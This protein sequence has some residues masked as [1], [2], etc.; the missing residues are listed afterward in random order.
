[1]PPVPAPRRRALW[2][3]AADL[4]VLVLRNQAGPA[5]STG[6]PRSTTPTGWRCGPAPASDSGARSTT[7]PHPRVVAFARQTRAASACCSATACSITTWTASTTRSARACGSSRSGRAGAKGSVQLIEIPT[8]DEIHDN[9]VAIW[10]PRRRPTPAQQLQRA[11]TACTGSPTS[12]I[13][14]RWRAAW[15]PASAAVA[16][17]A[18]APEG[19]AQVH[20]RVPGRA[21]AR[22]PVW[23]DGACCVGLAREL[24]TLSA[25]QLFPMASRAIGALS[26][27]LSS[28]GRIPSKCAR[29]LS[30]A[31]R[32]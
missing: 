22:S 18:A 2:H 27:T 5:A 31:G 8:D 25:H 29:S 28:T 11:T 24:W 20:G 1:M 10:V 9:V 17:R 19:R 23:R 26:L 30:L 3:R 21:A 13:R 16:S 6:G 4:D 12:P 15:P 14:R 32:P 7:R